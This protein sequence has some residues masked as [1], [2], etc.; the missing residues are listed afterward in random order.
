MS[1]QTAE[2]RGALPPVLLIGLF[3]LLAL[4]VIWL[5]AVPLGPDVCALVL[6]APR[7]CFTSDRVQAA[8][9]PTVLVILLAIVS[10][11]TA[12]FAPQ[13]RRGIAIAGP[14]VLAI[15]AALSYLLVA[16]IPAFAYMR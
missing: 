16:W 1:T 3:S 12:I 5:V 2:Q 4:A 8:I 15:I 10:T 13:A 7:N 9:A 11:L 14:V 6:P